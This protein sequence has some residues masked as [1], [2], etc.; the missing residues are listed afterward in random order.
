VKNHVHIL[1]LPK[2]LDEHPSA[3]CLNSFIEDIASQ[4]ME[5]KKSPVADL[6]GLDN[7]NSTFYKERVFRA[8]HCVHTNNFLNFIFT[9]KDLDNID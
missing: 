5:R 1:Q 7:I 2:E 8:L 6:F 4:L 9:E 3:E